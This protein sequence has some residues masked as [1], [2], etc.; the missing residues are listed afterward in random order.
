VGRGE[1]VGN[2]VADPVV[3]KDPADRM[4]LPL[5]LAVVKAS[6]DPVVPKDPMDL[7]LLPAVGE[8][9]GAVKSRCVL[10]FLR[11]CMYWI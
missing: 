7:R 6:V 9:G 2:A 8:K 5:L 1:N 11:L 3:P 10:P 4:D